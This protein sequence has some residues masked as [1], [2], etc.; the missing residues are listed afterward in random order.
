MFYNFRDKSVLDIPLLA[1]LYIP[2][3]NYLDFKLYAGENYFLHFNEEARQ[4][5]AL[6]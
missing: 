2:I 5:W 6:W 4:F 1:N 3:S